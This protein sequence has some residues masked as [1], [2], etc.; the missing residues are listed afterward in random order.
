MTPT[1]S[2][3]V[4]AVLGQ[5]SAPESKLDIPYVDQADK[6]QT[7]DVYWPKGAKN[8]PVVF[9]IHGGGWQ[10]GDKKEVQV[11][12]QAFTEKGLVFVSINYRLLP[13]VEIETI[14]HDV[15]KASK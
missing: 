7:L 12:P 3:L 9:W 13:A 2:L 14:F 8:V 15:A 4:A 11:K 6:L 1:L 10:T 5:T